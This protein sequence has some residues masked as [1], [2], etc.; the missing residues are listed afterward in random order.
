[1][2]VRSYE[3]CAGG[4]DRLWWVGVVRCVVL[5]LYGFRENAGGRVVG[6]GRG[7]GEHQQKG[8]NSDSQRGIC[9]G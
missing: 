1:M 9:G 6:R 4:G 8:K 5:R 3:L 7:R 2:G